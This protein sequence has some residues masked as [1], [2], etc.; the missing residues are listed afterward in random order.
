MLEDLKSKEKELRCREEE[1]TQAMIQQ[2]MQEAAL[3][4]REQELLDR[5]IDV[6]GR[7]AFRLL[8]V[9][10]ISFVPKLQR[11]AHDHTAATAK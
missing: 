8:C 3:R 10:V 7:Y 11:T 6:L 5:E 2:K 4:K 1:L 9:N